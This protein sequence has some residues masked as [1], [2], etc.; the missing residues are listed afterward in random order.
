V[1]LLRNN[2]RV[3]VGIRVMKGGEGRKKNETKD[4]EYNNL[5]RF[6]SRRTTDSTCAIP[7]PHQNHTPRLP[8]F[9]IAIFSSWK[10]RIKKKEGR[11]RASEMREQK[12]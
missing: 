4:E 1:P 9:R 5:Y 6:E 12:R 7:E 8:L 3:Q 11:Q 10:C 2:P